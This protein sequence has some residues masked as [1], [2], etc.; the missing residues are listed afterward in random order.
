MSEKPVNAKLE[1]TEIRRN[2]IREVERCVCK[3]RQDVYGDAED[4]FA[5]IAKLANI[6]LSGKLRED[7]QPEDIAIV[8]MCIKMARIKT[9]PSHLDSWIDN[10][11]YAIC[12]GGIVQ[13]KL[14]DA[15]SSLGQKQDG[16]PAPDSDL[17]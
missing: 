4:N 1:G 14:L 7:L 13:R 5:D 9:T 16:K 17:Q 10:A 2:L 15:I 3:N 12:G 6:M 8:S 11:G